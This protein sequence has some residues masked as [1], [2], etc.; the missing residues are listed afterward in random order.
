MVKTTKPIALKKSSSK[1]EKPIQKA[2]KP[3]LKRL[4][5]RKKLAVGQ[6]L[7]E[8]AYYC[9]KKISGEDVEVESSIGGEITIAFELL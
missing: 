1:V 4:W 3:S 6:Y 7:S 2:P 9:V 8:L 5:D